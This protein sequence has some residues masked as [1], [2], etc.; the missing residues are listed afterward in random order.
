MPTAVRAAQRWHRRCKDCNRRILNCTDRQYFCK[1]CS[2]ESHKIS[3]GWS[4][5]VTLGKWLKAQRLAYIHEGGEYDCGC[6]MCYL[7]RQP[8]ISFQVGWLSSIVKAVV[9]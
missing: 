4:N 1:R 7:K 5:G 9:D 6:D 8:L 3:K 2:E